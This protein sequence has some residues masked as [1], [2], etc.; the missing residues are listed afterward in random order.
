VKAHFTGEHPTSPNA[1][2]AIE[3]KLT[4]VVLL[5]TNFLLVLKHE[6]MSETRCN[7]KIDEHFWNAKFSWSMVSYLTL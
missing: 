5:S 4:K 6:W 2:D 1:P 3:A 7:G